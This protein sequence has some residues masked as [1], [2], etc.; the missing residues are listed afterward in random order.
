MT[1]G[2]GARPKALPSAVAGGKLLPLAIAGAV[3]M[4]GAAVAG[5]YFF[6]RTPPARADVLLHTVKLERLTVTV[7]E[8]G[9]LESAEN[10]DIVCKVRAGSKGYASTIN[11]VIADGD[12]VKPGQLLMV[13]DDSALKEQEDNQQIAFQTALANKVKAEKDYDIA[14]T[15]NEQSI[16]TAEVALT[17]ATNDLNNYTGV[18]YDSTRAPLVAVAGGP[19]GLVEAGTFR[20]S[21]DDQLGKVRLGEAEVQQNAERSAWAERMVKLNYMSAAQAQSD[22]SKL[23]SSVE[24]LRSQKAK[25]NQLLNS[26]RDQTLT[27]LVNAR[28][29]AQIGLRKATQEAE[30]N[31]VKFEAEKKKCYLIY[32]QED[33]KLRDLV[34]QRALCKIVAPN[35]IEPDSMVVYYKAESS[36]RF[37]GNTQGVI[38]Q[39]AQ[40]KEGQKMLRIP[41]LRKMQVNTKVHEA[42]VAR[43][44][45]DIR[46]PTHVTDITQKIRLLNTDPFA[47][48]VSQ[49]PERVDDDREKL[50]E[51]EYRKVADGQKATIRV[52][53]VSEKVFEGHVRVKAAVASQA[54]S[55]VSDVKLYQTLVM[56]DHEVLPDGTKKPIGYEVLPDGTTRTIEELTPDMTA[57][58]TITVDTA[59]EP[60]LTVP[61]QAVI[62][63][64]EMGTK[65]EVFVK[66]ATGFDR[67]EIKLGMF[68]E[69]MVEVRD[70]LAE[71]DQV[72]INPKVL[73]ATDDKTKTREDGNKG[74]GGSKGEGD[75]PKGEG[76]PKGGE[77]APKG[78]GG[79]K[80]GGGN[81]K[82]GGGGKGGGGKG[83]GI[84]GGGPPAG[85]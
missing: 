28:I 80:G 66:T 58:V 37:S 34:T 1:T 60:V 59:K 81:W 36:N 68:N 41:N 61:I 49:R 75:A 25:L 26:E 53:A 12:R 67:R 46:V 43:I 63:G 6:L 65:R 56:I 7:S 9:T 78:E 55:W 54:D 16:A 10:R 5:W 79:N 19:F 31:L 22:K 14:V 39:G 85:T 42:M 40:V 11:R 33:D 24:N 3:L 4:V 48:V 45:G 73:L 57:E 23:D 64:A 77:G 29:I 2:R 20:Q 47:R 82:G 35:N 72:V 30:S 62:G 51:L 8:K 18:T 27:K 17:A 83:G 21:V 13:L 76:M 32:A 69:K 84:P 70:G 50:Y 44:R 38:E 71:G 15:Q 52:D 74:K